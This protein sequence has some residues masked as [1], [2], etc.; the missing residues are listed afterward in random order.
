[1]KKL[2][3]V[4]MWVHVLAL[5]TSNAQSLV[6]KH[7]PVGAQESWYVGVITQGSLQPI[8]DGYS[9]DLHDNCYGNQAQP[10]LLSDKG[11]VVW[12]EEPFALK[13]TGSTLTL[14]KKTGSFHVASGGSTLR[15]AYVYASTHFFSPSGKAP[16]RELFS[17]PQ[18]NTWIELLYNQNQADVLA[19]AK[20]I[21][22][23]GFPPGVIMIDDNWQ[24]DYGTWKFREGRFPNPTAMVDTLHRWGFKVML[25]V[26]P[27]VSPDSEVYR[28]LEAKDML[29]KDADGLPKMV[30]WWNGVSAVLDL[31]DPNAV[32]WF[33]GELR[34][35]MKE[36]H[37]DG[38]KLDAGDP[39]FYVDAY[40]DQPLTP[41][42]HAELFNK[43]GLEYEL[44]EYRAAWKMGGQPLAQRLRDKGHTWED[45]QRLIPDILLQGIMGYPFTC[46]DMIGGGEMGSFLSTE[47]INQKLVVRSA[48]CHALMPMMQF[49][50]APWRILDEQHLAAV[51]ASIALRATYIARIEALVS[52]AATS[53]EPI[54]RLMEYEFPN[55]GL[56]KVTDQFMVGSSILVAPILT[57]EDQRTVV[58]PKGKWTNTLTGKVVTGPKKIQVTA[59]L[60]QLPIF[61]KK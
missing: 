54:V 47:T 14:T 1:M 49:S 27:F 52:Q 23:N 22:D 36:H 16:H 38:Y 2:V 25:W 24:E 17:N 56:Q 39:E 58:L 31:S 13:R 45:L 20:S 42:D 50:V 41:N 46:P 40:G 19:Y 10:L 44:N 12:S 8:V 43:I 11:N 18:Y 30:R 60:D 9:V 4:V 3:L 32:A 7:V 28:M 5:V 21:L 29:M 33:H 34:G 51:K 35:L 15:D 61:I 6:T 26:C 59:N 48:Q 53:G 57:Q 37:I 55:Q